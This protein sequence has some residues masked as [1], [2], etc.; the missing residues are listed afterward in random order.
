[1]A[2]RS[3]TYRQKIRPLMWLEQVVFE[4]IKEVMSVTLSWGGVVGRRGL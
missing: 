3:G 2:Y 4:A 1:M